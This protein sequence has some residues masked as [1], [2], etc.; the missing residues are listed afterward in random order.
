MGTSSRGDVAMGYTAK[1][2]ASS[3]KRTSLAALPSPPHS[4][5]AIDAAKLLNLKKF[6]MSSNM[7]M[8]HDSMVVNRLLKFRVERGRIQALQSIAPCPKRHN[9]LTA[10]HV[11]QHSQRIR[12]ARPTALCSMRALL[13]RRASPPGG[14]SFWTDDGC[15]EA[16]ASCSYCGARL[17]D[18]L[19]QRA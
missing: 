1:M 19:G 6:S 4:K 10:R 13:L 7:N 5:A 18:L 3:Q 2:F 15:R 8:E 16:L 9:L 11:R 14:S 12:G 17:S